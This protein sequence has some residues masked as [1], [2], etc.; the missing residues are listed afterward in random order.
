M[1]KSKK[2]EPQ[3]IDVYVGNP[4]LVNYHPLDRY[5]AK[6]QEVDPSKPT[7]VEIDNKETVDP[8]DG[9]DN[10]IQQLTQFKDMYGKTYTNLRFE[11]EVEHYCQYQSDC[12]CRPTFYLYGRRPEIDIEVQHRLRQEQERQAAI[13]SRDRAEDEKL[14]AKFGD[15]A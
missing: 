10:L 12:S 4:I 2:N 9:L 3:V 14:K 6:R 5:L 11:S 8:E 13:E 15:K 7:R 1:S